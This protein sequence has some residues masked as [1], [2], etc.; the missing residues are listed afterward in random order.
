MRSEQLFSLTSPQLVKFIT[1]N[2]AKIKDVSNETMYSGLCKISPHIAE[3]CKQPVVLINESKNYFTLLSF[4]FFL[5]HSQPE[6]RILK[7]TFDQFSKLDWKGKFSPNNPP[8][9]AR[10]QCQRFIDIILGQP[11]TD[12]ETKLT[13]RLIGGITQIPIRNELRT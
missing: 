11:R 9:P 6:I 3:E 2:N 7:H 4:R 12:D 13:L 10:R 1:Q 5:R 8:K